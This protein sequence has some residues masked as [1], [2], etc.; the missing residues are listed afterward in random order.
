MVDF[1]LL[2]IT[3]R[4]LAASGSLE[5]VVEN[6]CKAGVRAVQL[7]EKDLDSRSLLELALRLREI[8]SAHGACLF[9]NDR[10]DI[11]LAAQADGI[12]RPEDGFPVPM[13]KRLLGKPALIGAS[14]HSLERVQQM[15]TD[16][17]DY[18]TFGPLFETP[19]KRKYGP[20]QGL[21]TLRAVSH[22]VD[23]PVFALGGITPERAA[24]CLGAGAAGVAVISAIVGSI[25]VQGVIGEFRAAMGSL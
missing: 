5:T 2:L 15:Q 4:N 1:R 24:D 19:S 23:I 9:V 21:S 25:D 18:V 20:P 10:V 14:T 17:A 8:T 12:H 13:A 7:R 11:A 22:A 16:R 6:A 3:D